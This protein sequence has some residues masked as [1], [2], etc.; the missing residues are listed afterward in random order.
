MGG[1]VR[2]SGGHLCI[3]LTY[4]QMTGEEQRALLAAVQET[5][6][7][8]LAMISAASNVVTISMLPDNNGQRPPPPPKPK[9]VPP[10]KPA[11]KPKPVPKP[12]ADPA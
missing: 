2:L 12:K 11:P 9:P 7:A 1:Q 5:V 6:V 4:V 10:P 8:H 3:D